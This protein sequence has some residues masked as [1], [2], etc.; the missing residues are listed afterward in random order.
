[1]L[2][3]VIIDPDADVEALLAEAAQSAQDALAE[4]QSE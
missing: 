3:S 1:V 2:E 4:A